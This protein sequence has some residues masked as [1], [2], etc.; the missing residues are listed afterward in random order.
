MYVVC[1]VAT[2][3][4]VPCLPLGFSPDIAV[5]LSVCSVIASD[6]PVMCEISLLFPCY[7]SHLVAS[8]RITPVSVTFSSS[9]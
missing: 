8:P 5:I 9:L 7:Q 2:L 1:R 3:A 4:F 6:V